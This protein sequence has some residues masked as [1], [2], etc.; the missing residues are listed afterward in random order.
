MSQSLAHPTANLGHATT[1]QS[2]NGQAS[3]VGYIETTQQST[4]RETWL[5]WRANTTLNSISQ[6]STAH[7]SQQHSTKAQD[8]QHTVQIM[9]LAI[10]N[11]TNTAENATIAL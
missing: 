11:N 3:G 4:A 1:E 10:A 5:H 9:Y 7:S 2:H 8:L 6:R